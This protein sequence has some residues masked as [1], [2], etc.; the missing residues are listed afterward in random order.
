MSRVQNNHNDDNDH[1]DGN[2]G[3]PAAV[4]E[5]ILPAKAVLIGRSIFVRHRVPSYLARPPAVRGGLLLQPPVYHGTRVKFSIFPRSIKGLCSRLNA[6]G[7]N[8]DRPQIRLDPC[9]NSVTDASM[10]HNIILRPNRKVHNGRSDGCSGFRTTPPALGSAA[11]PLIRE[12]KYRAS[13][14][15][16]ALLLTA[17]EC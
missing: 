16:R 8:G 10:L 12:T 5:I 2:C 17:I 14:K 13:T 1:C 11:K 7:M 9:T 4:P 6:S 3:R 15:N